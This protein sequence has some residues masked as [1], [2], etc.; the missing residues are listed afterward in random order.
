MQANFPA[1]LKFILKWEGGND[2][3]PD[4][5]GGRTSRGV[6]QREYDAWCSLHKSP[7]GDVW[8]CTDAT[9]ESIYHQAYW[10]PYCDALPAGVDLMFFDIAVNC[11]MHEAIILLQRALR[12]TADG[13]FGMVT[14]ATVRGVND[15]ASLL[16]TIAEELVGYYKSIRGFR[17]YGKGWMNRTEDCLNRALLLYAGAV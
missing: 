3:D 5:P 11:G 9:V 10:N 7:T 12:V 2:D 4:D 16:R 17:K 15:V 13:H 6:T 8:K 14:A 1:C